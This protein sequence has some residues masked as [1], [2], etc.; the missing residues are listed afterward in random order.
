MEEDKKSVDGVLENLALLTDGMQTLFPEGKIIV[1]Y[2]LKDED[3]KKIQTNFRK[4]DH[5]HKR[6]SVDI[7]GVE[8]VFIHEDITNQP[9]EEEEETEKIEIPVEKISLIR[10]IL[11]MFKRS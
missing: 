9:F 6:F 10:K 2:E 11:S 1:L 7:S 8:H 5:H 3:F 4:I